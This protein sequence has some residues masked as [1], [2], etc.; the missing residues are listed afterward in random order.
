MLFLTDVLLLLSDEDVDG[1]AGEVPSFADLVFEEAFVGFLDVLG[2]V[3]EEHERWDAGV[4]Q[5]HAVLDFDVLA[6]DAGG[7]RC[8]DDGEH[9]LVET[10]GGD[11]GGAMQIDLLCLLKHLEDAL[12]GEGGGKDDGEVGE[13]GEALTDGLLE[14]V[15]GLVALIGG[16]VPLVDHD[17]KALPVPVDEGEDVD[18]LSL[19]TACG[20]HHQDADVA[21]LDGADAAH[22]AVELEV[23]ADLLFLADTGSIHEV[24][25]EAELVV[26]GIDAVAGG[27]GDVGD[28]VALL[29]DEGIDEAALAHVG[30]SH[31]GKAGDVLLHPD[32]FVRREL[33]DDE[34]EQ[35]ACA[36]AIG[37]ADADGIAQAKA[38]ELGGAV[39]LL[40]AVGLVGSEDDGGV[41]TTQDVGHLLVEIGNAM[42]H[43]YKEEY[44]V[45]L[46]DGNDYLLTYFL[47]KYVVAVDDPS[48]GIYNGEFVSAPLA[49]AVL[50]V[51]RSAC[52]GVHDGVARLGKAV[53]QG[54]FAHIGPSHD[55]Q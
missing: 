40:G 23:L 32:V 6:L 49:L 24:E 34:V 47:F 27:T 11:T 36:V 17:D 13:G 39:L 26:A 15:D 44:Q 50:T 41:G 29:A 38:V 52:L 25:V 28:D 54:G 30:T 20:I 18:V 9:L 35:V 48:A 3:G 53:E 10:G 43:I 4:G 12:P 33:A 21:V 22:H 5:L 42:L 19:D 37:S 16:E 2:Q 55:S 31:N 8:L 7:R 14:V 1:C 51:A 45:G 46:A